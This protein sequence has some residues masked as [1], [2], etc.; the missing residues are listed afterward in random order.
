MLTNVGLGGASGVDL[1]IAAR[2]LV[3]ALGVVFLSGRE[4]ALAPEEQ[5]ALGGARQLQS[6]YDPRDLIEALRA[7]VG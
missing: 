2:R 7:C 5:Q 1:A 6:R 3:P 4:L